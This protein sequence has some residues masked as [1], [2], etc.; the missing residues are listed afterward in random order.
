MV[1]SRTG[2][3]TILQARGLGTHVLS[4]EE[5][6]GPRRSG[7]FL[8][9]L[10][11]SLSAALSSPVLRAASRAAGTNIQHH[12]SSLLTSP[13]GRPLLPGGKFGF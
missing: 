5:G 3:T 9:Y 12:H 7:N 11:L 1:R 6:E 13:I 4:W 2:M 8:P 10:S